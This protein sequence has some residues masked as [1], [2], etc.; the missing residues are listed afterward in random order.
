MTNKP[1]SGTV[2]VSRELL[3]SAM[4]IV[5]RNCTSNWSADIR[6]RLQ[7]LL[8]Q[9]ADQQGEPFGYWRVH[10]DTPLQGVFLSH[11]EDSARHVQRA[12]E[13]GFAVTKLY[14]QPA[15]AKVESKL[16]KL[17]RELKAKKWNTT[18][19]WQHEVD[20]CLDEVAKLNGAQS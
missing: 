5:Q 19:E 11:Y 6:D 18:A 7:A 2:S 4:T 14:A 16:A 8:A 15:T 17:L 20:A 3:E 13:M 1:N 10:P 9:P 12:E